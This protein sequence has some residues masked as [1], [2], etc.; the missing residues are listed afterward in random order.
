MHTSPGVHMKAILRVCP[1]NGRLLC[2]SAAGPSGKPLV[3]VFLRVDSRRVS[4]AGADGITDGQS[5][6]CCVPVPSPCPG[7]ARTVSGVT[8]HA[9]SRVQE[10]SKASARR[11]AL[12]SR[13]P[14]ACSSQSS[15]CPHACDT[16]LREAPPRSANLF[17]YSGISLWFLFVFPRSQR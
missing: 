1:E 4:G 6:P 8:L 10:L 9:P 5:C 12:F 16:C 13:Q 3:S 17:G 7:A 14:C 2:S 11:S 15:D